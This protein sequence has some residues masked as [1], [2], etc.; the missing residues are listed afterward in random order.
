MPTESEWIMRLPPVARTEGTDQPIAS[1]SIRQASVGERLVNAALVHS[2]GECASLCGIAAG[3]VLEQRHNGVCPVSHVVPGLLITDRPEAGYQDVQLLR[4]ERAAGGEDVG[5][6]HQAGIDFGPSSCC[7][8]R[9]RRVIPD[10]LCELIQE[11][12]HALAPFGGQ[13]SSALARY[14]E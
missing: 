11:F 2:D 8:T 13:A 12:V 5:G 7:E 9:D 14:S 3:F 6:H 10:D 1:A 4:A